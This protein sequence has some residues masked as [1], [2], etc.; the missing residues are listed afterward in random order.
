MGEGTPALLILLSKTAIRLLPLR[1]QPPK[2]PRSPSRTWR[3]HGGAAG[4]LTQMPELGR[5][6]AKAVASLA[7]LAPVT[8]QSGVWH[9]RTFIQ[10]GWAR[11][12]WLLYMPALAAIRYHQETCARSTVRSSRRESRG[13]SRWSP[14]CASASCWPTHGSN[15]TATGFPNGPGGTARRSSRPDRCLRGRPGV[16]TRGAVRRST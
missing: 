10:G 2:R 1:Q 11:A 4:L 16:A 8:R 6:D 3:V 5:L 12:R 7:G 9:G 15:R 13:R 14:S